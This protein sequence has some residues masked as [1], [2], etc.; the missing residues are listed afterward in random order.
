MRCLRTGSA[1]SRTSSIDGASRPSSNA[2]ARTASISDWLARGLGPQ[3]IGSGVAAFRSGTR[4]AHQREDRLDHG[5]PDRQPAHQPLRRDQILGVHRRLGQR[6]FGSGGFEQDFPL[7]VAVGIVDIDL[8]QKAIELRFRQRIGAFLL[9]WICVAS[10]W[11]GFGRSWRVP[12]TVTCCSCIACK[13]AD[14]VRGLAR[15]I[16]SAIRSWAKTGPEM[17]RKLRLPLWLSSSTSV[18]RILTASGPA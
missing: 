10:T 7:G 16:S 11:N 4:G 2:R 3:A 14:W 1:R 17:K 6:L 15:L 8:H 18:P 12:A 5:F 9:Q 13:S